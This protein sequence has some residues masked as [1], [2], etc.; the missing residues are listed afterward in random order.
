MKTTIAIALT[1]ILAAC[2]RDATTPAPSLVGS[3]LRLDGTYRLVYAADGQVRSYYRA[4]TDDAWPPLAGSALN[5]WTL[6]GTTLRVTPPVAGDP[7]RPALVTCT[8]ALDASTL[9]MDCD[10][11]QGS[12]TREAL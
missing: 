11:G 12:F 2:G 1:L 7:D 4:T 5:L 9:Q 6:D 3:W 10:N 8:I